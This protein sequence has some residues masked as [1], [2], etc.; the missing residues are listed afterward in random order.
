[1]VWAEDWITTCFELQTGH[2]P[3]PGERDAIHRAM[4]LLR[5]PGSERTL[6]DFV[7]QVQAEPVRA[8]LNYYTLEGALGDCSTRRRIRWPLAASSPSR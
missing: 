8:A 7:S 6:T 4:E 2:A 1:M 5:Q 3:Q